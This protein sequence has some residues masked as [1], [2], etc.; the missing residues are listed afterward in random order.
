MHCLSF[1]S[2]QFI[3]SVCHLAKLVFFCTLLIMLIRS[4]VARCLTQTYPPK[5]PP[6]AG[7]ASVGWL[8]DMDHRRQNPWAH[9][10]QTWQS[11][12]TPDPTG[13]HKQTSFEFSLHQGDG[14][15]KPC[16]SDQIIFKLILAKNAMLMSTTR[17][18]RTA[19]EPPIL[20]IIH[21]RSPQLF[22]K[23]VHWYKFHCGIGYAKTFL[24]ACVHCVCVAGRWIQPKYSSIHQKPDTQKS[25]REM[26]KVKP[27]F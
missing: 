27:H 17:G 3:S 22:S 26:L 7:R 25:A 23:L 8:N 10:Q 6:S 2:F 19:K 11:N 18:T 15:W 12:L 14:W 21:P 16:F 24:A 20:T 4:S 5:H 1:M 9:P 13:K